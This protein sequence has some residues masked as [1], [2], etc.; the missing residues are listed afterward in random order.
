MAQIQVQQ[1]QIQV[2]GGNGVAAVVAVNGGGNQLS[3]TSLYVGDLDHSV[4]DGQLYDMFA[5]V[6]SVASVRVC[7]D[8]TTNLSLGY[9][10]VNYNSPQDGNQLHFLMI[11]AFYCI[12]CLAMRV[13]LDSLSGV[14]GYG[15][16]RVLITRVI[17]IRTFTNL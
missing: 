9:G 13:R 6:A 16:R 12:V 7:K 10:Y 17:I 14:R 2:T 4:T 5:Q 11:C 15:Y 8:I 1:P 3:T